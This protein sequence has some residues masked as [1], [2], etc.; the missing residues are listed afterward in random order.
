M[1]NRIRTSRTRKVVR[2]SHEST[3]LPGPM[4]G[5]EL[6]QTVGRTRR[7]LH[8]GDK[9]WPV[10]RAEKMASNRFHI[11]SDRGGGSACTS[12]EATQDWV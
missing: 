12:L 2:T 9:K 4:D 10:G 11:R 3:R 5:T 8:F 7:N 6:T 1:M